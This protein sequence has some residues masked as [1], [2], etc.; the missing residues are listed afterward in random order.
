MKWTIPFNLQYR[1]LQNLCNRTLKTQD[2]FLFG[3]V[4]ARTIGLDHSNTAHFGTFLL[5]RFCNRGL[6][7]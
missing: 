1:V 3:R 4:V 6:R 7:E 5:Q 2:P